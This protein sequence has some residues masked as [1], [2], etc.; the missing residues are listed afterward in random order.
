MD[1]Q[2]PMLL[3]S[4]WECLENAGTMNPPSSFSP[5]NR[6]GKS[7]F[8]SDCG[9]F[10]G[11]SMDN[12]AHYL[13]QSQSVTPLPTSITSSVAANRIA[14]AFNLKGPVMS[15]DTACASSLS[16]L[17]VACK[18][19]RDEDCTA[20]LVCGVN[21]IL[22][23]YRYSLL[24]KMGMLAPDGSCK[25]FD[26]SANGYVRG[27]GCGSVLLMPLPQAEKEGRRILAV[28]KSTASNNNGASSATL[29]S[30][31]VN[32]QK[33]LIEK[34]LRKAHLS[35]KDVAYIEAHGTGTKLGDPI[36]A[37]AIQAVFGNREPNNMNSIQI[38][39]KTEGDDD[40]KVT[41]TKNNICDHNTIVVGSIKANIGHLEP[42]AG[43]AGLIKA[44]M[45]L[46]HSLA[47]G[48]ACLEK[49]NPCFRLSNNICI[50]SENTLL[51]PNGGVCPSTLLSA[52]V[53]S[54]GFGGT[55][56]TTVLQQ[57]APLPHMAQT[58]CMLL[59]S[60]EDNLKNGRSLKEIN[61]AIRHLS[62][63]FPE[64]QRAIMTCETIIK[65]AVANLGDMCL[66]VERATPV[67]FYY[68][69]VTLFQSLGMKVTAVGGVDIVGEVI[70]LV[71]AN[72]LDLN[73][74]MVLML[75]SWPPVFSC[76]PDIQ[77]IVC[78]P[79]K[80]LFSFILEKFCH[81]SQS[82]NEIGSS[83]YC[84]QMISK[85]RT[86]SN[87]PQP[88][89]SPIIKSNL[90][91]ATERI[92]DVVEREN[93]HP[94]LSLMLDMSESF[95]GSY[96][97]DH[98]VINTSEFHCTERARGQHTEQY[99]R[100]KL[101]KLRNASDRARITKCSNRPKKDTRNILPDYYKRY[102]LRAHVDP[103]LAMQQSQVTSPSPGGE[104][105]ENKTTPSSHTTP[106]SPQS[107][108]T[109][110]PLACKSA[111]GGSRNQL[112]QRKLSTFSTSSSVESGYLTQENSRES[113]PTSV[114][115]NTPISAP[116][117]K[118]QTKRLEYK[119]DREQLVM[120]LKDNQFSSDKEN[121]KWEVVSC[122][123]EEIKDDLDSPDL[124]LEEVAESGMYELGLDSL[125]V[126]Q[127]ADFINKIYSVKMTFSDVVGH[128]TLGQLAGFIVQQSPVFTKS[129]ACSS[130]QS[131]SPSPTLSVS[132]NLHPT[133]TKKGYYMDPPL[134][135]IRKMPPSEENGL[136]H[137]RKSSPNFHL[138]VR[139]F[140]VGCKGVGK[141]V[142]SGETDIAQL[143][144][145]KLVHIEETRV[146]LSPDQ[147]GSKNLNKPATVYY[148]NVF[149][150]LD[151][152]ESHQA[153]VQRLHE[154]CMEPGSSQTF[155][156]YQADL[157]QFIAKIAKFY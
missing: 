18:S 4:A 104:R 85:L 126:M 2:Q 152:I 68:A 80:P 10:V 72:A 150:K 112:N 84:M 5:Q 120:A 133:L 55:N 116:P 101:I 149:P 34:A 114:P 103:Q 88:S 137:S 135:D 142:F 98:I 47:P 100:E 54:F 123:L 156:S 46:E 62:S 56:A 92:L 66:D 24:N 44:V 82:T 107:P 71:F 129:E 28:V 32:D 87:S 93:T 64:F 61:A 16:A 1:P 124:P 109:P 119:L 122:I 65:K 36:E 49:L 38:K 94:V 95:K 42:G 141:L 115:P 33:R 53:N 67:K 43:I 111:D 102:P 35:R 134:E 6:G 27:E 73:H 7:L 157:G 125:N 77:K 78:P 117:N 146:H 76:L 15:V 91:C 110:S 138:F 105:V 155:V 63:W 140:T 70:S 89:R 151:T 118:S 30:P 57:Y 51:K 31:S 37:D 14:R 9:V 48:N 132:S 58:E 69:L 26:A 8:S 96:H 127:T 29:T 147:P 17:D 139:D 40:K 153:L 50:P 13:S 45:V 108:Q 60:T 21:A 12:D 83:G 121:K 22:D 20:A 154:Q 131:T 19:L 97:G 25:V 41:K 3:H 86:K 75:T 74:A 106:Q 113:L 59:F 145:D 148:E 90:I 52:V 130:D 128:G 23:P 144:L 79:T 136:D 39:I 11:I 81:P 143:N 99:I